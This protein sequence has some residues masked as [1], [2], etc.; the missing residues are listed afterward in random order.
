[1][2]SKTKSTMWDSEGLMQP[3]DGFQNL[4]KSFG[5]KRLSTELEVSD[6][7]MEAGLTIEL[8]E[9]IKRDLAQKLGQLMIKDGFVNVWKLPAD[10]HNPL[11]YNKFRAEINV[12]DRSITTAIVPIRGMIWQGKEWSEKQLIKALEIANPEYMI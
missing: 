9:H 1:M 4:D 3:K 2:Y 6:T 10:L 11:A 12:V 8:E 5:V 7:A